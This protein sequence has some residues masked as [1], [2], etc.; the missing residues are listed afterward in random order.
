MNN[1]E[2]KGVTKEGFL[3]PV[4]GTR[5]RERKMYFFTGRL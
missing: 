3:C 1:E 4:E 5:E 2:N